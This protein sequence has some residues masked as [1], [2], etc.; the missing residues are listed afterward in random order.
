MYDNP[1]VQIT[2]KVN[3]DMRDEVEDG[4]Y[5]IEHTDSF[6]EKY[7][8]WQVDLWTYQKWTS[9]RDDMGE[10]IARVKINDKKALMRAWK[11]LN[12]KNFSAVMTTVRFMDDWSIVSSDSFYLERVKDA[13]EIIMNTGI[14]RQNFNN[15]K[16][17]CIWVV[18]G[19]LLKYWEVEA[20]EFRGRGAVIYYTSWLKLKSEELTSYNIPKY[21]RIFDINKEY[22]FKRPTRKE[23]GWTAWIEV[24][25]DITKYIKTTIDTIQ[26][27]TVEW[28]EDLKN[29]WYNYNLFTGKQLSQFWKEENL[30]VVQLNETWKS[31]Y[32]YK[33]EGN[34][35]ITI[36]LMYEAL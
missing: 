13:H 5:C 21:E 25:Q 17:K 14:D 36:R 12:K 9:S 24:K 6:F 20:I 11:Q 33:K 32:L 7:K 1:N 19:E 27:G 16:T 30:K 3:R 34:R 22:D 10:V 26:Q 15:N 31:L 35:E 2:M 29:D 23:K 4:I 18:S 28:W 8:Y